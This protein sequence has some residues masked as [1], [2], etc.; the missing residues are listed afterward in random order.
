MI[1]A[2]CGRHHL[3]LNVDRTSPAI[4]V[5]FRRAVLMAYAAQVSGALVYI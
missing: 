2:L 4:V 1:I 5:V 3:P